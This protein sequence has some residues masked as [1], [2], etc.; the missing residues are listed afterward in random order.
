[1]KQ[2]EV[3]TEPGASFCSGD[4]GSEAGL[5]SWPQGGRSGLLQCAPE[6]PASHLAP[7]PLPP[8]FLWTCRCSGKGGGRGATA[9]LAG[10]GISPV[11]IQTSPAKN[12]GSCTSPTRCMAHLQSCHLNYFPSF[13]N[14]FYLLSPT[15]HHP[16]L[17]PKAQAWVRLCPLPLCH[18]CSF[19]A[20]SI[21]AASL[22]PP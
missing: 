10:G 16:P 8:D 21:T 20:P 1:M 13:P 6:L 9:H 3:H 17:P 12:S 5:G 7:P 22:S 14:L 11:T 2:P 15:P 18:P 4:L 19:V